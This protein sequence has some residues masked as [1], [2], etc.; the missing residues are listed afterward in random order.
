MLLRGISIKAIGDTEFISSETLNLGIKTINVPLLAS[1]RI[2][3][4]NVLKKDGSYYF[5]DSFNTK[6][7]TFNV[8]YD[9]N[10]YYPL[11]QYN[12]TNIASYFH[13]ADELILNYDPSKIYKV[14]LLT[15]INNNM[16]TTYN[17]FQIQFEAHPIQKN[18]FEKG[19]SPTWGNTPIPW[20]MANFK[21][22]GYQ[23]EFS[24]ISS[25]AN[26]TQDN[27]GTY[28]VKPIIVLSGTGT[29]IVVTNNTT[30]ES[31]TYTNLSNETVHIDCDNKLVYADETVKVNKRVNFT[32]DYLTLAVGS[33]D[34]NVTGSYS[35]LSIEFKYSDNYL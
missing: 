5:D 14:K 32:G 16:F 8:E 15:E 6:L 28:E 9:S 20:N 1:Y 10:L 30:N 17:T 18:V 13:N 4:E 26:I 7:L 33:N 29:N 34:I 25:N 22:G 21:W 3:K 31:F 24:N 11:R 23:T 19:F 12:I 2:G 27:N 35:G